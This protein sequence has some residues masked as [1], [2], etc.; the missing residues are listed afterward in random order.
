VLASFLYETSARDPM[1]FGGSLAALAMVACG[2]SLLPALR[3]ARIDP[4]SAIRCE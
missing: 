3:A 4:M 2:A 1:V